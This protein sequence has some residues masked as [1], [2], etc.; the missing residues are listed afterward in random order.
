MSDQDFNAKLEHLRAC[1]Y[2]EPSDEAWRAVLAA[3]DAFGPSQEGEAALAWGYVAARILYVPAYARAWV[4]GRSLI[5][6]AG[7]L[8]TLGLLALGLM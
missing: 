4:P 5:W 7:F 6:M 8:C 2:A 3:L 1:L